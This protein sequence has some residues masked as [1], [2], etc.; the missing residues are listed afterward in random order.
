[1][2]AG[3]DRRLP[4][5]LFHNGEPPPDATA[6]RGGAGGGGGGGSALQGAEVRGK[7][8]TCWG[9]RVV[10]AVMCWLLI[11]GLLTVQS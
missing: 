10:S 8:F 7:Y 9:G 2:T 1:M 6:P 11:G 4:D 3:F 5:F